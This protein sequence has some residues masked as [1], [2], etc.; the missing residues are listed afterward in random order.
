MFTPD[1][2][3]HRFADFC[4]G[5]TVQQWCRNCGL[6]AFVA[7]SSWEPCLHPDA[8]G[9][10]AYEIQEEMRDRIWREIVNSSRS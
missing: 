4:L 9:G 2:G 1:F 8:T 3:G 7:T 5:R 10:G 6:S